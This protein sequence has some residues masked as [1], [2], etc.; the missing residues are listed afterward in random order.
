MLCPGVSLGGTHRAACSYQKQGIAIASTPSNHAAP[1]N[2]ASACSHSWQSHLPVRNPSLF[3]AENHV[4]ELR[5]MK[6]HGAGDSRGAFRARDKT[7]SS[8][9]GHVGSTTRCSRQRKGSAH[10]PQGA[11]QM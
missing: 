9:K 3:G 6:L 1:S 11:R 7:K 4:F 8:P 2:E 5:R 10:P